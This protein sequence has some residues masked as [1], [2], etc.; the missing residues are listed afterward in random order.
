MDSLTLISKIGVRLKFTAAKVLE[1]RLLVVSLLLFDHLFSL[2][3]LFF[4]PLA[5]SVFLASFLLALFLPGFLSITPLVRHSPVLSLDIPFSKLI[6]EP[7]FLLLIL[8]DLFTSLALVIAFLGGDLVLEPLQ[9]V[10]FSATLVLLGEGVLFALEL[11]PPLLLLALLQELLS[12]QLGFDLFSSLTLFL[13]LLNLFLLLSRLHQV[14][15]SALAF[16]ENFVANTLFGRVLVGNVIHGMM[17][18]VVNVML[19]SRCMRFVIEGVGRRICCQIRSDVVQVV[20]LFAF[21]VFEQALVGA[22]VLLIV[23]VETVGDA[24]ERLSVD[25]V[26]DVLTIGLLEHV[27][28][29]TATLS[30]SQES[31]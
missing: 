24:V 7:H 21:V 9:V 22:Q 13:G 1:V 14:V 6:S 31:N 3:E 28:V 29:V 15:L 27:S 25:L 23:R 19:S 16:L 18:R 26:E 12:R 30:E 20:H 10:R 4:S 5:P 17:L 2:L 8:A 11:P